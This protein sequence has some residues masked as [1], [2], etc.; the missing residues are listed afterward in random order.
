[1]SET[2]RVLHVDDEPDFADLTAL[3]LQR[4][5]ERFD[6]ETAASACDGLEYLATHDVDCV[7]S[8][9]D[10]AEIN[11][12]EFLETVR[13]DHPDLPFILFTGKGSEEVA[14]DAISAGVTDYLQK[15]SASSQYAVLAN[16]IG[17]VVEQ[18]RSR[19]E[20]RASQKRHSLFFD[21][22]PIGVIEWSEGFEFVR[23][24][25]AATDI[26][27]YSEAELRG[28]S[29]ELIVPESDR[30]AV[31]TVV[32]GLLE[33]DGGYHSINEN[34]RKD[35]ERIIC[36][37]HN[38]VITGDDGDVI[39]V[40]S[41]F[42]DVTER[43]ERERELRRK[44]RRYQATFNDPNILCSLIETDGTV[45]DINQT[46][47]NYVDVA[48]E[49]VVGCSFSETPWFD[50]SEAA[51]RTVREWIDRAAG[52]E[53]VEFE[54][55]LV[56]P[57]GDPY[58]VEGVFRP[59]RNSDEEVVSLL[60]SGRDVTEQRER[61]R[62]LEQT[63]ALL[64]TL[65]ETLP[66]GVLAEDASRNV[67]SINRRLLSLF[68]IDGEPADAIGADC[69]EITAD[70]SKL[71]VEPDA[72]VERVDE[73][74]ESRDRIDGEEL[75][76]RDDRAFVRS[77]RPIEL[78]DG[79]GHLWVYHDITDR[80][81]R[82]RRLEALNE[83]SQKLMA[84]ESRE[85]VTEIGVEAARDILDLE[86]NAIHLYDESVSGLVPVAATDAVTNSSVS[87]RRSPATRVSPGASTSEVRPSPWT[88]F[89]PTETCTIRR[90]PFEA[91]STCR[92]ACTEFCS[93]DHR[94]PKRSISE[95]LFS[96]RSWRVTSRRPSNRSSGPSSYG[97]ANAS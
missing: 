57:N 45:L 64:S 82:E 73:L 58:T 23:A 38:R 51:Q 13:E 97:H 11:G 46:A 39:A 84:T 1:M 94:H 56:H 36:E 21:R 90:R 85:R 50:H 96:G 37:W 30:D 7:V 61:K 12:I 26:L 5:D 25:D 95:T 80:K 47:M 22:S 72:F 55:D 33:D 2:I 43:A 87:C 68:D 74:V 62:E 15:E 88:R 9:Y 3:F 27:G 34:V 65:F 67:L 4:N 60:I 93:R 49:E 54:V 78:L 10:M 17:N 59:V 19:R 79:N 71:F 69:E 76:L 81:E 28:G 75:A 16:R 48:V 14:S 77:Y 91:N 86:A 41:Q 32:S 52:G 83:T 44:E 42:Q 24:N 40:F 35:G 29:W 66:V 8:D 89:T 92:S 63:T 53:Y 70:V 18:S 31:D 20:L 6:V